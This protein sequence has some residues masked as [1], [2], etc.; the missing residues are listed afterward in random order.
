MELRIPLESGHSM[1]DPAI[2]HELVTATDRLADEL[3][4]Q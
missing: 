2:K 1:Y 4:R 3:L